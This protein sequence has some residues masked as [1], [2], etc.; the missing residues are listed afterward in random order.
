MFQDQ[1]LNDLDESKY[2]KLIG[3]KRIAQAQ[4][5]DSLVYEYEPKLLLEGYVS[6]RNQETSNR[7]I[8]ANELAFFKKECDENEQAFVSIFNNQNNTFYNLS[9]FFSAN[10][11]PVIVHQQGNS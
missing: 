3:I 2:P 8:V 7:A 4:Q 9:F 10:F 6:V 1:L 5:G 11:C